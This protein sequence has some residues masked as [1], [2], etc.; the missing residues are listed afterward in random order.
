MTIKYPF[1]PALLDALPE[2]LAELFRGLELTLLEEIVSR[3]KAA[4]Q[5]N[6]VT[7]QDIR[8]LR[9]MGIDLKTIKKAIA[10]TSNTGIDK[11]EKLLDDVVE[12]NQ[13]YYTSVIDLAGLTMPPVLVNE[14]DIVAIRRQT[15]AAYKNITGS[16]GFLV[17]QGG[18]LALLPPAKAYEWALDSALLQVQTGAISYEQAI[19]SA[20][21]ELADSGLKV[22]DYESGHHNQ[23]DVAVRR[24]VMTGVNQLNAKYRDQ[25]MDILQTDLVQ[26]QAHSGARDIDGPMGWENHKKWQG[27]IYRW[28]EYTEKYPNASKGQYKDFEETCGLGDVTGILGAN[29]RHSYTAFLE[30]VMEPTYSEEHLA[31]IDDGLGCTFD[32]RTYTA[33]QATQK[34]RQIE[35]TIRKWKRRQA[36]AVTEDDKATATAKLKALNKKYRDF[37]A[38]AGL[39]EQRERT[40]VVY[41]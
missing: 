29:C 11:L 28:K 10:E 16:M 33:Y 2:D 34:Q 9:A 37:S 22:V 14:A 15:W 4:G 39:P 23:V 19:S 21:R 1:T 13:K 17:R 6:E 36:G 40:E 30:G 35:E 32:G 26:V 31:H 7:V 20:V 5:L 24:A 3:L 12:R 27:R 25:S 38:A 18:R 41:T 8:A